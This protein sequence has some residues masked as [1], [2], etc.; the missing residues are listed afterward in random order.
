M[1]TSPAHSCESHLPS[2][3]FRLPFR[4]HVRPQM[5]STWFELLK[6]AI[7]RGAPNSRFV[8]RTLTVDEQIK[9]AAVL[10]AATPPIIHN[11]R[12]GKVNHKDLTADA[13]DLRVQAFFTPQS[14][15][16]AVDTL[17]DIPNLVVLDLAHSS[18]ANLNNRNQGVARQK[19]L[20]STHPRLLLHQPQYHTDH[21]LYTVD[22]SPPTSQSIIAKTKVLAA[23]ISGADNATAM[24]SPT[25]R[26]SRASQP[27]RAKRKRGKQKSKASAAGGDFGGKMAKMAPAPARVEPVAKTA[28]FCA[29]HGR[30]GGQRNCCTVCGEQIN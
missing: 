12:P 22:G 14:Y 17:A 27:V 7:E 4:L 1:V 15:I 9:A 28:H 13:A 3:L 20:S 16:R 30:A 18:W 2:R 5:L 26:G 23:R 25:P 19:R 11:V 24:A 6:D 21:P 29:D 10:D 8:I